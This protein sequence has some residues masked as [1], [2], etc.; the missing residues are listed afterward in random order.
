MK[1]LSVMVIAVLI[2]DTID[3]RNSIVSKRE[4][5][6]IN[7]T[8]TANSAENKA[9]KYHRTKAINFK[10]KKIAQ[11][12]DSKTDYSNPIGELPPT[13]QNAAFVGNECTAGKTRVKD[14]CVDVD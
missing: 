2:I 12:R 4:S 6:P 9:P 10:L 14:I 7:T 1:C 3:C 8:S 11:R 5:Q 13:I